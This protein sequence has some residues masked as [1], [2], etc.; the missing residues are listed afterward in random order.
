[1]NI[2]SNTD[3][4]GE[5]IN[6]AARIVCFDDPAEFAA[7]ANGFEARYLPTTKDHRFVRV[8]LSLEGGRLAVATRPPMLYEGVVV[9]DEGVV[10]F[11]LEDSLWANVNGHS[12]SADTIAIWKT[13]TDYRVYQRS[14]MTH[15][16]LFVSS[17]FSDHDWPEQPPID[18]FMWTEVERS[19][20]LRSTVKS[21]VE[22]IREEP[23]RLANPNVMKGIDRSI[24]GCIDDALSTIVLS[25][26]NVATSRYVAI[27]RRA[28]EYLR[29][30]R[31]YVHSSLEVARACEVNLRTLHNAFI[32]VLGVSLGRYLVLRRLW[33]VRHALSGA[34]PGD[35]VKSI[36]LDCGFWHLGR[37]SRL[38]QREFGEF[39]STTLENSRSQR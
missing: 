3:G 33:H 1:M 2:F 32:A 14:R 26:P 22:I 24:T 12:V 31:M 10:C 21:V 30:S 13:G 38:Y 8:D 28:E 4:V 25:A 18:R 23:E 35:L 19:A 37:F 5:P 17:P 15:C 11:H 6:P 34:G 39:P 7:S 9:A 27:C 20:H 36:A 16:W 29:E